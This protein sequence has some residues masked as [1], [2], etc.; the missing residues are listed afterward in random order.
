MG[1]QGTR[2]TGSGG[3]RR[4]ASWAPSDDPGPGAQAPAGRTPV[5]GFP[6]VNPVPAGLPGRDQPETAQAPGA[7]GPRHEPADRFAGEDDTD[8]NGH[9]YH[10]GDDGQGRADE[11][12]GPASAASAGQPRG[13]RT[14]DPEPLTLAELYPPRFALNGSS[15]LRAAASLTKDCTLAVYGA[16]LQ[17]ALQSGH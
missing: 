2:R 11:P 7:T 1:Y 5:R 9:G 12:A 10:D 13:A 15:Y 8:P 6:P 16:Q 3:A 17:A 14:A 4:Q